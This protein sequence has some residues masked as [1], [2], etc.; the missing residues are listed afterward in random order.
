[1]TRETDIVRP[2]TRGE[3]W[4]RGARV[5]RAHKPTP[6]LKRIAKRGHRRSPSR[7]QPATR[8]SQTLLP[9]W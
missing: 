6:E 1:M 8:R 4:F 3:S 7:S 5:S 9:N 2:H